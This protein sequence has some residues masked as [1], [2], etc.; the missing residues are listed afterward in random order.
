MPTPPAKP[1]PRTQTVV[2]P[3]AARPP[4]VGTG[5]ALP[6]TPATAAP[7]GPASRPPVPPAA[8]FDIESMLEKFKARLR[9]DKNMLDDEWIM[10]PQLLQDV[11]DEVAMA[12]SRRDA[13][14]S[15][16]ATIEAKVAGLVR[17]SFKSEEVKPTVDMVAERVALHSDVVAAHEEL[18]AL[19]L[20]AARL[21][22]MRDSIH[23]RG[24]A[25]KELS[26]LWI[27][28][29]YADAGSNRPRDQQGPQDRRAAN[30]RGQLHNQRTQDRAA[31]GQ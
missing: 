11:S 3:P 7:A 14:K 4:A 1:L 12:T 29:Y 10:Y 27:A 26:D 13:A 20:D 25:L 2:R 24:T 17:Q 6:R 23:A 19:T 9:I 21:S 16:V 30:I 8:R 5:G 31:G 22:A 18:N 28:G 15:R